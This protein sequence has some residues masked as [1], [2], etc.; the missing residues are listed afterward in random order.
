MRSQLASESAEAFMT[1]IHSLAENCEFG[2]LK[3]DLIV[4]GLRDHRL[5]EKLQLDPE[6]TL[7]K[8]MTQARQ[9]ESVKAQQEVIRSGD[10]KK[11]T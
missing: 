5:S 10:T 2:G 1:A 8:A 3:E 6:L 9:N 4:V 11:W 7:Q